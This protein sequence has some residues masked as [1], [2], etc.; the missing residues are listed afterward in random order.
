MTIAVPVEAP[1]AAVL[2]RPVV[3]YSGTCK[4]CRW[5]AGLLLRLD[6]REQL[7]LVPLA[8]EAADSLL[9]EIPEAERAECWWLVLRDG[10]PVRGDD[11]GGVALLAE[12]ELTS[13]L[14]RALR[15]LRLSRLV[16]AFDKVLAR[17][18]PR[19]GHF[20]PERPVVRRYP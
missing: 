5:A 6:R 17:F 12:L 9:A 19:L 10:T 13:G 11:G 15:A 1:T 4:F 2:G 3:L 14:A 7:A 18:R 20:V 8:D 16:D